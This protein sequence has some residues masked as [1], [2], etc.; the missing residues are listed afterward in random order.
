MFAKHAED[1]WA[2]VIESKA[3]DT[4]FTVWRIPTNIGIKA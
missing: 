2:A 4:H 1:L 3:Q